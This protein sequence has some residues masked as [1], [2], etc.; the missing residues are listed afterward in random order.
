[1]T[2]KNCYR[3]PGVSAI[4]HRQM[5]SMFNFRSSSREEILDALRGINRHKATGFDGLSPR[6]LQLVADEI[7]DPLTVIFNQVIQE[8]EWP[9]EW[10]R[11][12]WVPVYRKEDP[13]N[14]A[15]ESEI[16]NIQ[17]RHIAAISDILQPRLALL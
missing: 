11:G 14:V 8:S 10:K 3:H 5:P 12:E 15:N 16:K 17:G 9:M 7:A 2:E 4:R 6:M 13:Q 1:M